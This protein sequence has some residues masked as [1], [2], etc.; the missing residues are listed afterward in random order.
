VRHF[1]WE[2]YYDLFVER[3]QGRSDV[4]AV[5]QKDGSFVQLHGGLTLDRFLPSQC[6][7]GINQFLNYTPSLRTSFPTP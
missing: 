5:Q 7:L 2:D 6:F 3:Y 4:V 1:Q